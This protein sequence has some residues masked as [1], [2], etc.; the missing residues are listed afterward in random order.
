MK[1]LKKVFFVQL[2]NGEINL[3][4]LEK[5]T[6][7]QIIIPTEKIGLWIHVETMP[8]GASDGIGDHVVVRYLSEDDI[9]TICNN[10]KGCYVEVD[11]ENKLSMPSDGMGHKKVVLHLSKM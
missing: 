4:P 10:G 1:N 9:K 2:P 5:I 6:D 7:C 11:H 8:G 3:I